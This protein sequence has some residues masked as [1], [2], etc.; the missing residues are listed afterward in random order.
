MAVIYRLGGNEG[1]GSFPNI[2]R[3]A[4][5]TQPTLGCGQFKRNEESITGVE[6]RLERH[7]KRGEVCRRA[8][9]DD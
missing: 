8:L 9:E 5:G 1:L 2:K 3:S 4:E 7:D 6:V